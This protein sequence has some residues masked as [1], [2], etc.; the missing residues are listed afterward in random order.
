MSVRAVFR[1]RA[2]HRTKMPSQMDDLAGH[3]LIVLPVE[4]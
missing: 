1:V 2:S 3:F 4:P